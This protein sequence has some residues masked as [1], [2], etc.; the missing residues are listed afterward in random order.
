MIGESERD[1]EAAYRHLSL[2]RS[3]EREIVGDRAVRSAELMALRVAAE[4]S[5]REAA[6]LREHSRTFDRAQRATPARARDLRTAGARRSPHRAGQPARARADLRR[7]GADAPTAVRT[8]AVADIDH[9]KEINDRF[10]HAVG[11]E[12]LQAVG[13]I[14]ERF[15][16][17]E[18]LVCRYGGEEFVLVL[19]SSD[20]R[21]ARSV[22]ERIRAAIE[23]HHWARIAPRADA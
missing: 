8:V 4:E 20:E 23:A 18:D 5:S 1:F 7:A 22:T 11:D 13:A 9:F 16:R 14:L 2:A 15:A 19:G 3:L 17:R 21:L 10:G 12:V 6:Q